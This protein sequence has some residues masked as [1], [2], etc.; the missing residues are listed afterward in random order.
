MQFIVKK[1]VPRNLNVQIITHLDYGLSNRVLKKSA[2]YMPPISIVDSV[3]LR[4]DLIA[5][6]AI[7]NNQTVSSFYCVWWR[8]MSVLGN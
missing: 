3:P 6:P 2:L 7:Q 1:K 8:V 4:L 5:L